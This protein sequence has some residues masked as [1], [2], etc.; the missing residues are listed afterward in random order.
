MLRGE[1]GIGKT[2]LLDYVASAAGDCR[3]ARVVGVESELELA[4]AAL[5]QL[6]A[7]M[8]DLVG[9]LPEP[10]QQALQV[11]FGHSGGTKLDMFVLGL[12]V[13]GLLAES[14][15]EK[16]LVC[17]VDDAQWLDEA[18][19]QVLGFVARRLHAE[20][21]MIVFAVREPADDRLLTGLPGFALEGLSDRD[22]VVLL[23]DVV[24]GHLDR[25]VRDRIIAETGGNPLALLELA[26]RG[27]DELLGGFALPA[28]GWVS[29]DLHDTYV[30]RIERLPPPTRLLMLLAAADPTG[31]ATLL[32]RAAQGLGLGPDAVAPAQ[33]ERLLEIGERVRF[34]HPLIRSA[35]YAAG[36]ADDRRTVH[37]A[38]ADVLVSPAEAERRIWHRAA[39]AAGPDEEIAAELEE[40]A[41]RAEARGGAAAA[42][43]LLERSVAL[44]ADPDVRAGRALTAAHAQVH[45]GAFDTALGLLAQAEADATEEMQRARVDL[46]RGQVDRAANNGCDAP[47]RLAGAA[48]RLV[49]L[50]ALLSRD[51]FLDA[52]GAAVVAGPLA[53]EGGDLE[54]V[55]RAAC[56][57]FAK[58]DLDDPGSLLLVGL[59]THITEGTRTAAPILRRAV[60]AFL[61]DRLEPD[62]S[63]HWGVLAGNAALALWDYDAWE[64]LTGRLADRARTAGALAPLANA[65][66]AYR[67]CLLWRGD[68]E[69]ARA[70]G[71]EEEAVKQATGTRRA[72]YGDLFLL[73]YQGHAAAAAPL[74]TAIASDAADRGEG[75]GQ[76]IADRATALL[77]L[78]LGRY[79]EALAAAERA[80]AGNLGPF[81]GQALPDL[82]EAAVRGRALEPAN[83]AL[84]RLTEYAAVA[85]S[86]WA[87]GLEARSRALVSAG[88]EAGRHYAQALEHLGRTRL[89][90]E[91]ARTRLVHGEW[92]RRER[93]RS[94]ARQELHVAFEEFSAMGADGFAER[95]RHELLA[96]GEKV[97]KRRP[98]TLYEMT[99]QEEH[100][101]RLAPSRPHQ[102]RDRRRALHQRAHRRVAP[103][104]GLRQ[105][106]HHLAA[107]APRCP[108]RSAAARVTAGATRRAWFHHGTRWRRPVRPRSGPRAASRRR[109][110][111]RRRSGTAGSCPAGRR[112][113]RGRGSRGWPAGAT[114]P[115]RGRA[116]RHP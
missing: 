33:A 89:R 38:L 10:Q 55:S 82:V 71:L 78:G 61:D 1:A 44:T 25:Q 28:T 66:N 76:Q 67:V 79:A 105:A 3:V 5:H 75:L 57:A 9:R 22:A 13:L 102:R 70:L 52:W 27:Q 113:A 56:A 2:T 109:D 111:S 64:A 24:P 107:R 23:G 18:S 53:Y 73:A 110:R 54:T 29:G 8:L 26:R 15:A 4:L 90:F 37:R 108:A 31:D 21:A 48:L 81:T 87:A 83:V 19:A 49:P 69:R 45:V 80:A 17:L 116:R 34:R 94:D 63:L 84:Q 58:R 16:P 68:V 86:D 74:L 35:A 106:R 51:T 85:D 50:D 14:A 6:C 115:P 20:S 30:Q 39:A 91:L 7:P 77:H 104:E 62:Q 114:R 47:V 46:L 43:A 32:W 11:A 93:R 60:D 96:T 40:T 112:S 36:S 41:M 99:P 92:L 101:A 65:L 95:A 103:A 12:A 98:D 42:A 59:A 88:D 100:I 72:S 97:R